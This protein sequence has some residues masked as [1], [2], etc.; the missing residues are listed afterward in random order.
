MYK[1]LS[2][3]F[4]LFEKIDTIPKLH[5]YSTVHDRGR[6]YSNSFISAEGALYPQQTALPPGDNPGLPD[7][8][9]QVSVV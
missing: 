2:N 4:S 8:N 3:F 5:G 1:T 6:G 7:D 9:T